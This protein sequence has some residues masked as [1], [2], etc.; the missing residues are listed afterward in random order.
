MATM[1]RPPCNWLFFAGKLLDI[2]GG[3]VGFNCSS[4]AGP[5]RL[6]PASDCGAAATE[7]ASGAYRKVPTPGN[8][9]PDLVENRQHARH[10]HG[11]ASNAATMTPNN[12]RSAGP[13][14]PLT[15]LPGCKPH[16]S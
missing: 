6:L 9:Y 1:E 4:I 2:D 11:P 13:A 16:L 10:V 8:A 5:A 12:H 14:G 3:P 15:L 7:R